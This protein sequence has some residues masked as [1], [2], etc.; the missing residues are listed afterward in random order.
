[1]YSAEFQTTIKFRVRQCLELSLYVATKAAVEMEVPKAIETLSAITD[2]L[3]FVPFAIAAI[4]ATAI[5]AL[6]LA[7]RRLHFRTGSLSFDPRGHNSEGDHRC[8]KTPSVACYDFGKIPF[9]QLMDGVDE[10]YKDFPQQAR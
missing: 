5:A 4:L 2:V 3:R 10:F 7:S 1:L 8:L 6:M 9:G